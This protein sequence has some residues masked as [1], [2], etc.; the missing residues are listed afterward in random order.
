MCEYGVM[1]CKW[2]WVGGGYYLLIA[3]DLD[4]RCQLHLLSIVLIFRLGRVR[5]A[6]GGWLV[7]LLLFGSGFGLRWVALVAALVVIRRSPFCQ[8]VV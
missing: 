4:L 7:C 5:R 1:I 8:Q 6:V 2:W 3:F